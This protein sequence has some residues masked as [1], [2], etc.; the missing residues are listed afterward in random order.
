MFRTNISSVVVAMFI[1][2]IRKHTQWKM[3]EY[4]IIL[5]L[6]FTMC[7]KGKSTK[8]E[9]RSFHTDCP[10]DYSFPLWV[11]NDH[12]SQDQNVIF[13]IVRHAKVIKH[14]SRY[15]IHDTFLM[16]NIVFLANKYLSTSVCL[17]FLLLTL[18]QHLLWS[19]W[20]NSFF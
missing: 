8:Q 7:Y 10:T 2:R 14:T 13:I 16:C 17:Y 15:S 20:P 11:Y 12:G 6:Y 3:G 4:T 9:I 18:G 19:G 1:F 5:L